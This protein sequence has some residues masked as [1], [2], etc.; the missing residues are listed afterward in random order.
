MKYESK[1]PNYV[2]EQ[3]AQFQE[4][5]LLSHRI[6]SFNPNDAARKLQDPAEVI[7][8]DIGGDK[9]RQAK[10]TIR[11]GQVVRGEEDIF[12]AKGGQGYLGYLETIAEEAI[13]AGLRVGISSAGRIEGSVL[14]RTT[15]LPMF[16][17]DFKA[18]YSADY[19]VLFEGNSFVSNDTIT[20]ICGAST[21]QVLG[22]Q[23]V[24]S[25]HFVISAS[26]I[27]SSL[28]RDN[29]L[30]HVEIGHVPV[31]EEF[32]PLHQT[33]PCGV[34]GREY[35]C[36]ERIAPARAGIEEIYQQHTGERKNG[37]ELAKLYNGGDELAAVLYE[38]SAKLVA[39]AVLG[40]ARRY[41]IV[42]S[43]HHT[44]VFHG[45][46]FE[47]DKYRDAVAKGLHELPWQ[48]PQVIYSR[49]LSQNIC[50]D[51]AAIAAVTFL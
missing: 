15:N 13:S 35:V 42:D 22:G 51:G 33:T 31:V 14:T 27:G 47:V 5:E 41:D 30:S 17:E 44:V 6:C 21:L 26:G 48:E 3:V 20:G 25:M 9:I 36:L 49:D 24:E 16:F 10:Y 23:T 18:A 29:E 37:I 19:S 38:T 34:E 39:H 1:L 4:N 45:G 28:L 46:N 50:L 40:V 43:S 32:N 11:D 2:P 7:A 12:T 8:V